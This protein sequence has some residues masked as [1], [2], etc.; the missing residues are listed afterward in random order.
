MD[1]MNGNVICCCLSYE[2]LQVRT[3]P[4]RKKNVGIII[5][6]SRYDPIFIINIAGLYALFSSGIKASTYLY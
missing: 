4:M 6:D 2:R 5:P 1:P 3:P